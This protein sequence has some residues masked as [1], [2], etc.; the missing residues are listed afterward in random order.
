MKVFYTEDH[1][2]HVEQSPLIHEKSSLSQTINLIRV[3]CV[4]KDPAVFDQAY[5]NI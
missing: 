3:E 2:P 1:S 5:T 4:T